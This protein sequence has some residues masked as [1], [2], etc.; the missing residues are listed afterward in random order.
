MKLLIYQWNSLTHEYIYKALDEMGIE[1][2]IVHYMGVKEMKKEEV[3]QAF[4]AQTEKHIFE[5]GYDALFSIN[6]IDFL[7]Q[8]AYHTGILYICWSYDSPS[9]GGDPATHFYDTNR[10]FLFDS[11]E[12]EEHKKRDVPHVYHMNLAVDVKEM[13]KFKITPQEKLRLNSEISFVGQ[14]YRTEIAEALESLNSYKSAYVDALI[15]IQMNTYD[16]NLLRELMS[17]DFAYFLIDKNPEFEEHVKN[18]PRNKGEEGGIYSYAMLENFLMR[19]V[20]SRERILLLSLL[21]RN[22]GVKL[23]GFDKKIDPLENVIFAGPLDY[24]EE[25]PKLFPCSKI[26]LNITVRS[27]QSAIPQ[28]CLDVMACHG[29]LMTNYQHDLFTELEDGVDMVVYYSIEDALE[30]ADFYLKHDKEREEIAMNGYKKMRDVL[31][32]KNQL[33]KIFKISG[34]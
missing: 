2:N 31:N 22:H 20:T 13:N 17:E 25:M 34:L 15:N 12:V 3:L 30:K 7:S 24:K 29:F 18:S 4:I 14:L 5:E 16:A 33:T 9:L 32:Y 27:I 23:F 6:Y 11:Y 10:I 26:N 1:Y 19:A 21:S 28:R 8:I